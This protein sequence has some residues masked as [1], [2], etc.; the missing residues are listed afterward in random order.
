MRPIGAGNHTVGKFFRQY[1]SKRQRPAPI[2]W[3]AA[4][5]E[6]FGAGHLRIAISFVSKEL[7][8]KRKTGIVH[9]F[10]DRRYSHVVEDE[11]NRNCLDVCSQHFEIR[12]FAIEIDMPVS[13]E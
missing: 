11:G 12:R 6:T 10:V 5:S 8:K 13:L 7:H 1:L 9:A 3:F 4:S 2:L